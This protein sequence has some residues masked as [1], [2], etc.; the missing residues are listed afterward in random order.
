M[1]VSIL[2]GTNQGPIKTALIIFRLLLVKFNAHGKKVGTESNLGIL[3]GRFL[4]GDW[5]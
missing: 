2:L 1:F 4:G 3:R 5:Y